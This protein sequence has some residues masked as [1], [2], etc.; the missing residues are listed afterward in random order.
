MKCY[1]CCKQYLHAIFGVVLVGWVY[2]RYVVFVCWRWWQCWSWRIV[3]V[4]SNRVQ[5]SGL[6]CMT[7]LRSSD[8][9]K[10]PLGV[11]RTTKK[12]PLMR[13]VPQLRIDLRRRPKKSACSGPYSLVGRRPGLGYEQEASKVEGCFFQVQICTGKLDSFAL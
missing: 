7:L 4:I 3:V 2:L 10:V 9:N 6:V 11:S 12:F 13:S 5:D 1:R 8:T